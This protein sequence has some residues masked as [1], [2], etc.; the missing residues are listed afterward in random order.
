MFVHCFCFR[1]VL[2]KRTVW[3]DNEKLFA[4]FVSETTNR[5]SLEPVI[6]AA[7]VCS[8]FL[9]KTGLKLKL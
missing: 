1:A 2:I 3:I 5:I 6:A 4:R 8:A 9:R 7:Q